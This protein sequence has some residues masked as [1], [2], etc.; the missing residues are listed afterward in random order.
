MTETEYREDSIC[1]EQMIDRINLAYVID[2]LGDVCGEK[3][4]HI[5]ANWQDTRA[6]NVWRKAAWSLH[7]LANKIHNE[8]KI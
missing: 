5:D 2:T 8:S 1:L 6:A 7:R 4:I 3:A